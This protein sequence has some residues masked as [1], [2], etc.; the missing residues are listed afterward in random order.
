MTKI[1]E[2]VELRERVQDGELIPISAED[3]RA[4]TRL[5]AQMNDVIAGK[6]I[7]HALLAVQILSVS[8]V[9]AI[10]GKE[11]SKALDDVFKQIPIED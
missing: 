3:K 6:P 2:A 7:L 9:E 8:S 11:W 10:A 4:A 1:S 5:A